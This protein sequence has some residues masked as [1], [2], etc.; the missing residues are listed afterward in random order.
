MAPDIR[1][2]P[3]RQVVFWFVRSEVHEAEAAELPELAPVP[4]LGIKSIAITLDGELVGWFRRS[5]TLDRV[6]TPLLDL[7]DD[8]NVSD[9]TER[10]EVEQRQVSTSWTLR[11]RTIADVLDRQPQTV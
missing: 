8:A 11:G 1:T 2:K 5:V 7:R 10:T 6:D 3:M 9:A 4:F